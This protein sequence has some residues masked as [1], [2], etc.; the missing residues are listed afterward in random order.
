MKILRNIQQFKGFKIPVLLYKQMNKSKITV[1][2][3]ETDA[4]ENKTY[5]YILIR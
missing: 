4:Y 2:S 3:N 5:L 1:N